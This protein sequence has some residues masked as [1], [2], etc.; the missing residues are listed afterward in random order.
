[1][2][3]DTNN[4]HQSISMLASVS[5][6]SVV[7]CTNPTGICG[8]SLY[9]IRLSHQKQSNACNSKTD[10]SQTLVLRSSSSVSSDIGMSTEPPSIEVSVPIVCLPNLLRL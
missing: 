5:I 7:F 10:T 4:I 3:I 8:T 2:L 1:M 6:T 9:P